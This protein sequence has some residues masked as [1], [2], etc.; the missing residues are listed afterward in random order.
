MQKNTPQGWC[1]PGAGSHSARPDLPGVIDEGQA[2]AQSGQTPGGWGGG[3]MSSLVRQSKAD[4][5]PVPSWLHLTQR[6]AKGSL[7]ISVEKLCGMCMSMRVC[8]SV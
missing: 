1:Q 2:Q 6:E 5:S 8:G 7:V 3:K 4:C